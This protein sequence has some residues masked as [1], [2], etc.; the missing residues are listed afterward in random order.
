MNYLTTGV[1]FAAWILAMVIL[2][3]VLGRSRDDRE[4]FEESFDSVDTE[5]KIKH[6]G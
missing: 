4:D 2:L 1:V 5:A 6:L 3:A